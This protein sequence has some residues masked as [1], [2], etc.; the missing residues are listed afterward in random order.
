MQFF[1]SNHSLD[2]D[3]REL[4]RGGEGIA[5]EPQVFDLLVYLIENRDRV[6]TKDNLIETIWD[7]RTVS[8]SALTSRINAA[9]KAVGDS[10]KDQG[11]IRTIARKGFRFVGDVR[12]AEPDTAALSSE[13]SSPLPLRDR[14]AI[15]VLPFTNMSGEPEQ[16][17]FSDGISEDIHYRAVEAAL[18][19][20][21][22]AQLLVHLQ[23]QVGALKA[24]RRRAWRWL[25]RRR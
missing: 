24:G 18:V 7:G 1:F 23:G 14:P 22:R 20:R 15:A 3:R 4:A 5:I 12:R 13:K 10:G 17:Y 16:E 11:L 9:R 6:V 25:R 8:E 21:D 19:L 2:L